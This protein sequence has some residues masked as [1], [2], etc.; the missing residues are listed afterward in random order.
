MSP[1]EVAGAT[2]SSDWRRLSPWAVVQISY[3][4]LHSIFSNTASLIAY[5]PIVWALYAN[6]SAAQ[7]LGLVGSLVVFIVVLA[8]LREPLN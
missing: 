5:L 4:S 7:L 8:S 1:A 6:F 3:S 2:G